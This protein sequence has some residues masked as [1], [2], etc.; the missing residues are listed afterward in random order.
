MNKGK[1]LITGSSGLI[2][3]ALTSLLKSQGYQVAGLLRTA[4]T[5][6]PFWDIK[7][8]SLS[9]KEFE[10][11]DIIIHLAG[12]NIADGRW[13]ESKKKRLIDSRI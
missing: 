12:E 8:K 7:Q 6:Q 13:S 9:L 3:S 10:N 1:V 5:D 4:Q 11:P 2:G